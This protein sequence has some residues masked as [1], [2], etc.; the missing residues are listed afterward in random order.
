[1][2]QM[3]LRTI[4][5]H[6]STNPCQLSQVADVPEIIPKFAKIGHWFKSADFPPFQISQNQSRIHQ[7][8]HLP[9]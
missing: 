7:L 1:M 2:Q 6:A 5:H 9:L 3:C 4:V 8:G